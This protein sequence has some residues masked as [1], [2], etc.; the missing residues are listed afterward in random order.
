MDALG[1]GNSAKRRRIQR[2]CDACRKKK[3]RCEGTK[4]NPCPTCKQHGLVCTFQ[5]VSKKRGPPKGL[6]SLSIQERVVWEA[7]QSVRFSEDCFVSLAFSYCWKC[8]SSCLA[9]SFDATDEQEW[10]KAHLV[11]SVSP[12]FV[13]WP[14]HTPL[15][16]NKA[17]MR[18]PASN[19]RTVGLPGGPCLL[20]PIWQLL[21]S[22]A[23]AIS[24]GAK[25]RING[26]VGIGISS[27]Q[28]GLRNGWHSIGNII[29]LFKILFQCGWCELQ[30]FKRF[31]PRICSA[32]GAFGHPLAPRQVQ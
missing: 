9:C 21:S 29:A 18:S 24:K 14:L 20:I 27:G 15:P 1:E 12:L 7:T 4:D 31:V 3:I 13:W 25:E 19:L 10:L 23:S 6:V 26:L 2:A 17:C 5:E 30:I 8:L 11:L 16:C 32:V 22:R 28:T